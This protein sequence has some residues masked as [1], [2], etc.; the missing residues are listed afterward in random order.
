MSREYFDSIRKPTVPA[1][2]PHRSLK[3]YTRVSTVDVDELYLDDD[4]ME[5]Q[6]IRRKM[7]LT[8]DK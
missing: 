4:E 2:R 3:D 7:K 5:F 8:I 1:S 6:K